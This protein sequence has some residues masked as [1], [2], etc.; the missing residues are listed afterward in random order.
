MDLIVRNARIVDRLAEGPLGIGV[1]NGRIAA[2][3]RGMAAV[4]DTYDASGRP[5]CGGLIKTHIHLDKSRIVR[6]YPPPVNREVTDRSARLLNC[7]D[8]GIERGNPADLVGIDGETPEQAIA[9]I[10]QPVAVWERGRRTVVSH[11]S[12]LLA[13]A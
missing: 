11:P 6:R 5:V 4:S 13:P 2:V 10:H 1:A 8:Y 3:G 9:E 12:E 7:R